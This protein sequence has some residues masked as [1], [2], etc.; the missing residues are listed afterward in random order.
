MGKPN[1][2]SVFGWSPRAKSFSGWH[3][4][5]FGKPCFCPCEN[6]RGRFDENGENDEFAFY[7]LK[8]RASTK[9]AKMTKIAQAKARFRKSRVC[10]F[11]SFESQLIG[12]GPF[13]KENPKRSRNSGLLSQLLATLQGNYIRPA[14]LKRSNRVTQESLSRSEN[15]QTQTVGPNLSPIVL[16]I[17]RFD[18]K[19]SNPMNGQFVL[20]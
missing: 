9:M 2:R 5:C 12:L 18:L 17:V 19:V 13:P 11:L 20:C 15:K 4:P 3:E 8:T 10:C 7:S 1:S 6:L 16:Y 14:P